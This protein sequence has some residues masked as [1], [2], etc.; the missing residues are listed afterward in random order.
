MC[1][2][3]HPAS[4]HTGATFATSWVGKPLWELFGYVSERMPKNDPASLSWEEYADVVAYLLRL[5][6]MPPGR[7]ELPSDSTLLKDI[8]IQ[9][10][11]ASGG[12]GR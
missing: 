8:R 6:G 3:C 11:P 7:V 12:R 4:T 2:S 9:S 1:V 10:L 5:N